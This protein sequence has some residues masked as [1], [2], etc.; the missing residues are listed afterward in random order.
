MDAMREMTVRVGVLEANWRQEFQSGVGDFVFFGL[1]FALRAIDLVT[2][3][4]VHTHLT[5]FTKSIRYPADTFAGNPLPDALYTPL[6][7]LPT[8]RRHDTSL[9]FNSSDLS[10]FLSYRYYHLAPIRHICTTSKSL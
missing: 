5:F 9:R 8:F 10:S 1:G 6:T 4:P 7:H 3:L 2:D